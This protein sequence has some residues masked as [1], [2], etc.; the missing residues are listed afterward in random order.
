MRRGT[1]RTAATF[2]ALA[3]VFVL[4]SAAG[5]RGEEAAPVLTIA[6]GLKIVAADNRLV[7]IAARERDIASADVLIARARYLPG[8]NASLSQTFLAY[9]PGAKFGGQPVPTAERNSLSY[10]FDVQQT[11]FDFGARS[12]QYEAAGTAAGTAGLNIERVRNLAALD[13]IITYLDLLETEKMENV[14]LREVER[15]V[16]HHN[17]ARDLY[18]EGVITRND[19]LQAE[20]RLADARQRLLTVRNLR[21]VNASRINNI[22][23]RPLGAEVRTVDVPAPGYA[24]SELDRAWKTAEDR[25]VELRVVDNEIRIA[26]LEEK[27]RRSEYFP[28]IFAQGGYNYTQNMFL[29]HE[30]NWALILGLTMNIF[31]GGG[32]KAQLAK[33]GFRRERLLDQRKKLAD[34]IKLDVE[35]SYFDMRSAA[36]R[37]TVTKDSIGQAEE[38]LRINR[39]RYREGIGTATDVLDAITLLTTAET[40][41]NRAEYEFRRA[42]A[43]LMYSMGINLVEEYKESGK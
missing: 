34:D 42:Q 20:V 3:F 10:G 4:L 17:N 40:N 36:E 19:L 21:A 18:Q 38:N 30:D 43:G 26:D 29:T 5:G 8:I 22:L 33:I 13:F 9:Q 2:R 24:E 11:L 23:S 41:Y 28:R 6:E 1:S 27:S 31:S 37:I 16:S 35:K 14:A 39:T 15:L 32:T 12:S 7:R 25:R